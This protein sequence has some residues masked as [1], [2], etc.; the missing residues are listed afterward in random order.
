VLFRRR[1]THRWKPR[2]IYSGAA[3]TVKIL[4]CECGE[5]QRELTGAGYQQIGWWLD[6]GLSWEEAKAGVL[7]GE[8]PYPMV[9]Q[10][11][12]SWMLC[13]TR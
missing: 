11:D 4:T 7:S 10:L 2:E 5:E 3:N 8:L 1:H 9:Q 6:L 12:G 13:D